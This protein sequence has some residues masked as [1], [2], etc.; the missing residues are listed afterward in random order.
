MNIILIHTI[1]KQVLNPC[2]DPP[3]GL[4]CVGT[5]L[6]QAGHKV[7]IEL[8]DADDIQL[9]DANVYGM[10]LY[11]ATYNDS[12]K[13]RRWLNGRPVIAG[14]PHATALPKETCADGFDIVVTGECEGNIAEIVRSGQQGIVPGEAVKNIDELP[15]WNY[16]LVDLREYRRLV[17]GKPAFS[18]MTS[19]GCAYR[20][21]FCWVANNLQYV[22]AHSVDRVI[23]E[24]KANNATTLRLFDDHF[25]M[26]RARFWEITNR[27]SELGDVN[28]RCTP[29]ISDLSPDV[30][31]QLR[32]SGCVL[33]IPG[34]ESGSDEML[35]RM[36][37]RIT[38]SQIKEGIENAKNAGLEV[39]ISIIIGFPGETWQ[40]VK[41]TSTFLKTVPFD[42]FAIAIFAPFPG[43]YPYHNPDKFGIKWLSKDWDD[44]YV[45][46]GEGIPSIT[47]ETDEL[48]RQTLLDMFSYTREELFSAGKILNIKSERNK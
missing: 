29:R 20:C 18:Y 26:G 16:N 39:R 2:L 24:L 14:G 41:E 42:D 8:V 47:F 30:C 40:T 7:S 45:L 34:V 1:D 23:S 4:L 43:T 25:S 6:E 32:D 33:I 35:R 9:D 10:S 19:R 28:Y 46:R 3:F 31:K 5:I 36:N 37:K 21:L 27:L 48:N 17:N 15:Y 38:K 11:T 13:I 44:Y 22:R 12:L